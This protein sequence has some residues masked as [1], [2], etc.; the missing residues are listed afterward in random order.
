MKDLLSYYYYLL[1]DKIHKYNNDYYFEFRNHSF[2][3]YLYNGK[4]ED[5]NYIYNLNNYMIYN[6]YKINRIITNSQSN[7]L[8]KKDN[9]YYILIELII[10]NKNNISLD[11]IIEFNQYKISINLLNRTNWYLLWSRKIDNIEYTINH[12]KNK[13]RLLY[14]SIFYYIGLTEN[15]I[16]YI[17]YFN[18]N[19]NNNNISICHKRININ[20]SIRDFYNPINLVIDYKVRDI[21]EYYKSLFFN[22]N[23]D[24]K[25]II[26]SFT[27]IKMSNVD[28]IYFYIRMLYPSYYF[29]LF[30]NIINNKCKEND[31][32][33]ITRLQEDYEY[34][35]YEI[36]NVIKIH[37]NIVGIEWINKKFAN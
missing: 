7:I 29:D 26:N 6:N 21:A 37:V 25:N 5:I 23:I 32:L 3:F 10:N 17:K 1:P 15:A 24:I 28:Y 14:S 30:D 16:S 11:N 35:L 22:K 2:C 13:Y 31:I 9:K 19:N 12:I 8:T 33:N 20:N 4:V 27:N 34:L 18:L 36:Y